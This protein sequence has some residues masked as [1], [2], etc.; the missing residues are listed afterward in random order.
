[1]KR[2]ARIIPHKMVNQNGLTVIDEPNEVWVFGILK[3]QLLDLRIRILE[4]RNFGGD[5]GFRMNKD[6][7]NIVAK[8][9]PE[10]DRYE[11]SQP[12]WEG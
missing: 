4:T 10:P 12:V 6:D 5:W 1:M 2:W 3:K 9:Y 11:N 7:A 8:K